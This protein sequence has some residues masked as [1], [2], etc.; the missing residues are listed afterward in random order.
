L[1]FRKIEG[2]AAILEHPTAMD[3]AF[4]FGRRAVAGDK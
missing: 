2:K 1:T 4:T 3:E